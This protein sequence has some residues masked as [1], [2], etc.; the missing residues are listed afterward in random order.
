M[1]LL[2]SHCNK[3][4]DYDYIEHIFTPETCNECDRLIKTT[5]EDA[6]R[7]IQELN[8]NAISR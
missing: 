5:K 3:R 2:V 4:T 6:E 7:E 1:S 8:K